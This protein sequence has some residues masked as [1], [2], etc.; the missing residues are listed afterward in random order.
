LNY[1]PIKKG[2]I[3][4]VRVFIRRKFK[5]GKDMVAFRLLKKIRLNAMEYEGYISGETLV[6][7]NDPQEIMVIS[8]WQNM[9]DW[10]SWKESEDR[11][12]IDALLE[13]LQTTPTLYES[14][15]FSKY[16]LSAKTGFADHPG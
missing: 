5:E 13:E 3:M 11:K 4:K 2:D 14:F 16:R 10:N 15:V 12:T 1:Q 6:S 7:T 8:T 9:E